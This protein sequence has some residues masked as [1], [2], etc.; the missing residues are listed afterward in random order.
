MSAVDSGPPL[1]ELFNLEAAAHLLAVRLR[2]HTPTCPACRTE[3]CDEG[4]RMR[5]ALRAVQSVLK[6]SEPSMPGEEASR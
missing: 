6:G 1:I 4:A 3:E 5:R 2:G